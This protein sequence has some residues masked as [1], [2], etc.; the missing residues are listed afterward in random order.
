LKIDNDVKLFFWKEVLNMF[1]DPK[2]EGNGDE[3]EVKDEA[4][5]SPDAGEAGEGED[6]E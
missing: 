5:S 4:E 6:S 1:D 2:P 3:A